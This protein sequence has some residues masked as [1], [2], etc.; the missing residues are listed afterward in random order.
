MKTLCVSV[1]ATMAVF[2]IVTYPLVLALP[3]G[4]AAVKYNSAAGD[5]YYYYNCDYNYYYYYYYCVSLLVRRVSL[6]LPIVRHRQ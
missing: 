2:A 1:L 6:R 4:L 3:V 5:Y